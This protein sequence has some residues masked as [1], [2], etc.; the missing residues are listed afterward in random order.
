[1]I[2]ILVDSGADYLPG[3]L[4]EKHIEM[5]PLTV[6]FGADNYRDGADLTRDEFFRRLQTGGEYPRTSQPSPAAFQERF[7]EAKANGDE[8]ICILLS[9]NVSGTY[10]SAEIAREMT[11]YEHIYLVDSRTASVGIQF[12]ADRA[13]ALRGEGKSAP[14]IVEELE[15][16]RGRIRVYFMVDTLEYLYR[17]GRLTRTEA[18][19]GELADLKPVLTL[20]RE[21]K[22]SVA[23]ICLGTASAVE[24]TARHLKNRSPE[25]DSPLCSLYTDGL[26]NCETLEAKLEKRHITV[27]ARRRI[28]C[29]IGAHIGPGAAGIFYVERE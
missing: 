23:D 3:E 15:R 5:V 12:L 17:G 19:L 26:T 11:D 10:Q 13:C 7:E 27:T 9:A 22:V 16:V 28:G 24:K 20:N 14:E 2:R 18:K 21:G 29:V 4:A 6:S 8:M 1:M 25:E